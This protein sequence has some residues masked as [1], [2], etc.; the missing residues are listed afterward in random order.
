MRHLIAV[1]QIASVR[2]RPHLG[3]H[4]DLY[5]LEPIC[6]VRLPRERIRGEAR[7]HDLVAAH[8]LAG[9][10]IE[11]HAKFGEALGRR[12]PQE[13]RN[14]VRNTRLQLS[15]K[16]EGTGPPRGRIEHGNPELR[17]GDRNVGDGVVTAG[18]GCDFL[19]PADLHDGVR[20]RYVGGS[21]V[22]GRGEVARDVAFHGPVVVRLG[23]SGDVQKEGLVEGVVRLEIELD[24]DALPRD[25]EFCGQD[26]DQAGRHFREDGLPVDVRGGVHEAEA[27]C[28]DADVRARNDGFGVG[29]AH[30]DANGAEACQLAFLD[31]EVLHDDLA[32]RADLI[33]GVGDVAEQI[34]HGERECAHGE[35]ADGVVARRIRE[36]AMVVAVNG[37]GDRHR[38]VRDR[39]A[40]AV[41]D[42]ARGAAATEELQDD[43]LHFLV[44]ADH[45]IELR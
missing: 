34:L 9:G 23:G 15:R 35:V 29:A 43:V 42:V 45:A 20:Y 19:Q 1:L 14:V 25:A 16:R 2:H 13:Q 17:I 44:E 21:V 37:G 7:Q 24:A 38:R 40:V 28:V 41:A 8:L 31:D 32:R 36:D 3:A 10:G 4:G 11:A 5:V 22:R 12:G 26:R 39:R 27:L 18:V 6:A 30:R 33:G